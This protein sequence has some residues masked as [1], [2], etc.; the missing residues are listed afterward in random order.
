MEVGLRSAVEKLMKREMFFVRAPLEATLGVPGF[1]GLRIFGS[2]QN[3]AA[4]GCYGTR[5]S[6]TFLS[7]SSFLYI[8]ATHCLTSVLYRD[9]GSAESFR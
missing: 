2:R 4:R 1:P 5:E 7:I 9:V 6:F 3:L 8:E